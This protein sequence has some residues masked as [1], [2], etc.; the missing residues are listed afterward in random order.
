VASAKLLALVLRTTDYGES[1]RVVALLTRERGKIS[2]FARG[3][4]A[5]RKRFGGT[6]EP[7]TLATA[8]LRERPGAELWT[9]ESAAAQRSF[10]GIRGDLARIACASYAC[11]LARAL[12]RDGEPHP[13]LFALLVAYLT[14]LDAAPAEPAA[15][16]AFELL[17]L[18]GAGLAPRLDD[19][20]RCGGALPGAP[21]RLGFS[22]EAGL[23]CAA[24]SSLA[25]RTPGCSSATAEA[26]RRLSREGLAAAALP[27]EASAEARELLTSFIE[28]QLG[29]RLPSRRFL[30]EVGLALR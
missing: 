11:D 20:A 19:C 13:D 28:H 5:S 25:P 27:P 9:L 10:G 21:A 24:C 15:L 18:R 29:G 23:L 22:P 3:A 7:F 16:R 1:D 26:L 8:E 17:A 30:D 14:R 2:A 12:V 4:R 6:L